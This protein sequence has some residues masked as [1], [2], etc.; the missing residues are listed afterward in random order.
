MLKW[1]RRS[2]R[3]W[4]IYLAIGAIV[5]VFIFFGVGSYKASRDQ[6]AAEVNGAIIP[7]TEFNRQ[8]NE[9]VKRYQE[10]TGGEVTPEMIKSLRLKEMALSQLVEEALLLQAGRRLGLEVTD[11]ELRRR[12]E[13]YPFFQQDG[14]FDKKRYDGL[15]SR[16]HLSPQSFE[17]QER[18]Q[19][20]LRKVIEEVTSFAKV[21]DAELQ[22]FFRMAKEEVNVDYLAVSP[23]KFLARENPPDDAVARYY[24]ENEAEFRLP[25]RARVNY[26]VFRTKD[27]LN[28]DTLTPTAVED[29]LKEHQDEFTRPRVIRAQ[30]ILITLPPKAT[31]ADHRQAAQKAQ[32]LLGKARAGEDFAGLARAHSQDAASRDKGGDLGLVPRGQNPPEWDKVAFGLKPGTMGLAATSKGI[33]LIRLEETKETERLPDAAKLVESRL[34]EEKARQLAKDAAQQAREELSRGALAQVAQKVGVTPQETPL[35]ALSGTVPGLGLQPAFNQAALNLKPQEISKVVELPEGFAVLKG[36]EHQAAHLPPLAQIKDQ[37][38]AALK[39]SLARKQAEQ[40]ASR[41][42]GELRQG[43]PWAQVAAAAGL[44]VKDSGFFTRF[45]GFLG[46]QQADSLT[47]AAFQLSRQHPYPEKPLWWQNQYYLLAFKARREPGPQEFQKEQGQMRAQF[48]NQKQQILFASWLDG[49]RRRAKIQIF[50]QP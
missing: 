41:L 36:L 35:I 27:Y 3:S 44:A 9:L 30:Q 46:Q 1:L 17:A 21:S 23:E 13:S 25:D 40:E 8:Y 12:I 47:G 11:A 29:Y 48:L 4:F 24:Q 18:Q 45:Q 34:K 22:E 43:K 16:H 15:L 19:L 39:K 38:K 33:Y 6:E 50:V 28:R 2:T 31:E 7:M 14:K 20:L 10:R 49:E 26:L 5:L 42:L 37:V 32:E